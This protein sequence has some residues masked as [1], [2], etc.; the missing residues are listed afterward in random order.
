MCI[1]IQKGVKD[2]KTN[3]KEGIIKIYKLY[4]FEVEEKK[5]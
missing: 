5:E 3:S 4:G 2:M 1:I